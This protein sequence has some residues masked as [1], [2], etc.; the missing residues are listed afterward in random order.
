MDGRAMD[1]TTIVLAAYLV[2]TPNQ[3]HSPGAFDGKMALAAS[4]WPDG[5]PGKG[6]LVMEI[7]LWLGMSPGLC[8]RGVEAHIVHDAPIATR[9]YRGVQLHGFEPDNTTLG[10]D[11][12]WSLYAQVLRKLRK[13]WTC[14]W[15]VDLD[16]AAIEIPRCDGLSAALHVGSD[17]CSAKIK[18][19]M[20]KASRHTRFNETWDDSFAAFL[21]DRRPVYNSGILGGHRSVFLP[22]LHAIVQRLD[23]FRRTPSGNSTRMV[24]GSD[25][26]LVNWVAVTANATRSNARAVVTGFPNG[27]VNLPMWARPM[28]AKLCHGAGESGEASAT[29]SH[30]VFPTGRTRRDGSIAPGY[31]NS[32]CGVDWL[33][34]EGLGK[35]WFGHKLPRSW[36]NLLRYHACWGGHPDAPRA[37]GNATGLWAAEKFMC[38]CKVVGEGEPKV[39]TPFVCAEM[40]SSAACAAAEKERI[41]LDPDRIKIIERG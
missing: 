15:V 14:A 13:P 17:G 11:R 41:R 27:P 26:L 23:A 18:A 34:S 31:C 28:D 12:R 21:A 7:A 25:M 38:E 20:N 37:N 19:W 24:V 10:N 9:E 4:K 6:S 8:R 30:F 22:A 3:H 35:F 39:R 1:D 2:G 33:S 16:V 29:E 36:L 40:R 32:K 5:R